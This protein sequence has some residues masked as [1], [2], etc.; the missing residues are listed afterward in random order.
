MIAIVKPIAPNILLTRGLD[1]TTELCEQF[2]TGN[3]EFDFKKSIYGAEA[4]KET[5][6]VTQLRKCAFCESSFDHVSYGDVEHF[7]PKAGFKQ[8]ETDKLKQPGYYWLAYVWENLFY[9]CQRCN[10]E[11]KKNLFPLKKG[12]RRAKSHKHKLNKEKPLLIDPSKEDPSK[13]IRFREEYAYAVDDCEEGK[14][15]IEVLGLNREPLVEDRRKRLRVLRRLLIAHP[16]LVEKVEL[17]PTPE[18]LAELQDSESILKE[19]FESTSVYTAMARDFRDTK[20]DARKWM[21]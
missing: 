4:V 17:N 6:R 11:F 7:R 8:K 15:T 2:E 18:L 20:R 10:Q 16:L 5:L 12:S 14:T 13:Y 21:I 19:S 3:F 1:A 9:S